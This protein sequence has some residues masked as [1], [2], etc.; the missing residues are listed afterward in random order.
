MLGAIEVGEEIANLVGLQPVER[1]PRVAIARAEERARAAGVLQFSA[2]ARLSFF[3]RHHAIDLARLR[4]KLVRMS[5][6][7][8]E[9]EVIEDHLRVAARVVAEL[10][11]LAALLNPRVLRHDFAGEDHVA[12]RHEVETLRRARGE[13]ESAARRSAAEVLLA[14]AEVCDLEAGEQVPRSVMK[15]RRLQVA[16]DFLRSF[17]NGI[18]VAQ[19][20][21]RLNGQTYCEDRDEGRDLGNS[22]HTP[23]P[24]TL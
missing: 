1:I 9:K 23:L 3:E 8:V 7:E 14:V 5:A 12:L 22:A 17:E 13:G 24:F 21:L 19:S 15:R 11:V 16:R 20:L 4:A 18:A 2:Q 10:I 6:V